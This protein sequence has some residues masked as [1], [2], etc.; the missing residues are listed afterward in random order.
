MPEAPPGYKD[1]VSSQE[2][3]PNP[4]DFG[5]TEAR[6]TFFRSKVQTPHLGPLFLVAWAA[7]LWG[8]V[9]V[10]E[11]IV[12]SIDGLFGFVLLLLPSFGV[13]CV[14]VVAVIGVLQRRLV[15]KKRSQSDWGA[16]Q[17]Y[18]AAQERWVVVE[19]RQLE[20]QREREKETEEQRR[21][22]VDWWQ[23]LNGTQFE[24]ALAELLRHHADKVFVRGGPGD[25]GVDIQMELEGKRI[26]VQCKALASS[27]SP[28]AVR[29]LY[30]TLLHEGDDE[31]WVVT[32]RGYYSSAKEFAKDK[33]I[34]LLTIR[35]LLEESWWSHLF[36]TREIVWPK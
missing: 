14:L 1:E 30:G 25:G 6:V 35:E 31:A 3:A 26:I 34:R 15:R 12:G 23:S 11:S 20:L 32:T 5:L 29:D 10:L 8:G 22:Q 28:G 18:V 2:L 24:N 9:Q 17:Q 4:K 33:P 13:V 27:V 16:F 36:G 21:K 7:T 19:K